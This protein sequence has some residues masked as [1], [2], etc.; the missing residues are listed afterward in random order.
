[1]LLLALCEV[2]VKKALKDDGNG[3]YTVDVSYRIQTSSDPVNLQLIDSYPEQLRL[4]EGEIVSEVKGST[5]WQTLSYKL[6]LDLDPRRF[7]L[8]NRTIEIRLAPARVYFNIGSNENHVESS[9]VSFQV[10]VIDL[11]LPQGGWIPL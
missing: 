4:V 10:N 9:D 8:S 11:V 2:E 5:N 3:K 7:S 6:A 1:L